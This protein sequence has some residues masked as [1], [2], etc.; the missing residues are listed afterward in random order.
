MSGALSPPYVLSE[1]V[2]VVAYL[3]IWSWFRHVSFLG[4]G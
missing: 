4:W 1:F 3:D 2:V